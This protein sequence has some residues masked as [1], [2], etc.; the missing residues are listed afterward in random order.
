MMYEI[1]NPD[2][3]F[4]SKNSKLVNDF[5]NFSSKNLGFSKPVTIDFI[6]DNSAGQDPLGKTAH[7]NPQEMSIVAVSYTHL[8]LPTKRIV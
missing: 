5:M 7:Y 8:T 1:I 3:L 6:E 4:Y 2:S